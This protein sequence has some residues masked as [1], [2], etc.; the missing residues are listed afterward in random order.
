MAENEGNSGA[1]R[2]ITAAEEPPVP[3]SSGVTG[4]AGPTDR[5]G[6]ELAS[7]GGGQTL[8]AEPAGSGAHLAGVLEP[9]AMVGTEFTDLSTTTIIY[10]QPD[11]TLLEGG[12]GLTAEE[13]QAVLNQLSK[14]QILQVSDTEAA[15]LLQQTQLV[16]TFPVQ[17]TV[18]D[19]SQLQ[20][21]I[22]QVTKSQNQAQIPQQ[23]LK[24]PSLNNNASQQL[25]TVAQHVAMQFSSVQSEPVKLQIEVPP[26]QEGGVSPQQKGVA[27][28]HPQLKLAASGGLSN[29]QIFHIQPVVNQGQQI[30]L[31]QNPGDPPIQLLLQSS[32]PV[33]GSL[34]PLVHKLTGQATLAGATSSPAP[35]P[36][37]SSIRVPAASPV[38]VSN[39]KTPPPAASKTISVPLISLPCN[40]M[41]TSPSKSPVKPP[42][43]PV[44]PS[45]AAATPQ[46]VKVS[47][48]S[49]VRERDREKERKVKKKEKKAVKVQTR[50]GRVSRP[51]KYKAKDY[52]F[53][54]TEDLADSHQSDSDDYSDMSEEEEQGE[55]ARKNNPGSS[56][57]STLTYSHKSRCHHCQTCDKSYIGPGG[58]NRHYKLNPTHAEPPLSG[59]APTALKDEDRLEATAAGQE[60]DETD[61]LPVAATNT[62]ERVPA[63]SGLR[64]LR[65][66]GPGRPRGRGRR[67][68]GGR[69]QFLGPGTAGFGSRPAHRGRH[70][71]SGG[72]PLTADQQGK[73]RRDR[74]QELVEQCE[75]EELTDV[76]LPRLTKVLSL[77]ELL[78]AKVD[79]RSPTCASFPDIYQEFESLQAHVRQAAQEYITG[80]QSGDKPVE[81]RNIEVARSLGILD[82]VNR[83]KVV[84]GASPASN[85]TNKNVR[86]MG[87]SKMLPPSKRFKM[88]NSITDEQTGG[89]VTV[90]SVS[91]LKPCSVSVSP[92][93]ISGGSKLQT[94]SADSTWSPSGADSAQTASSQASPLATPMEVQEEGSISSDRDADAADQTTGLQSALGSG[95]ESTAKTSESSLNQAAA[96]SE[97]RQGDA[98][99][100]E[101]CEA[102]ELQEGQE[103]Y[104]QAEQLT[105]QL[106]EPGSDGIVIVNGP[107]GTTMHIQTPE[108]VPLEAVQALLGIEASDGDKASP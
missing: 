35:K 11:G 105:V 7:S 101:P 34:L 67:R 66:R 77:W 106:A 44:Q 12:S 46:A 99:Q 15:Q 22:D 95:S 1:T 53:I 64:G 57:T 91:P 24:P 21:V 70:Q 98:P 80:P 61:K 103:I 5:P 81:V 27:V 75:A 16:E 85:L 43:V 32:T 102:K 71:R 26:K 38:K 28:S 96:S 13:Q 20:Q 73:R 17:K 50:S 39:N 51:P 74:L 104:I 92:L 55:N 90:S 56:G 107:D 30:L 41:D 45:S 3:L 40:G 87:N 93:V 6:E 33:V 59:S 84:P 88:E 72:V 18:L 4:A 10:L 48:P 79:C 100:S 82:E 49:A 8:Q 78:L 25:K 60:A 69:G 68:G 62:A 94:T 36:A 23:D 54:K 89:G 14:H 31:Q 86:Y 9:S 42:A 108:G 52:K 63:A 29:A 19:P 97:P 37:S 76:V 47:T 2:T 83:M 65:N 58:L